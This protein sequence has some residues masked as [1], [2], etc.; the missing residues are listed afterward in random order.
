MNISERRRKILDIFYEK[1]PLSYRE[2]LDE[3][4]LS[5]ESALEILSDLD[6]LVFFRFLQKTKTSRKSELTPETQLEIRQETRGLM[7][8]PSRIFSRIK[9]LEREVPP[10]YRKSAILRVLTD[11]GTTSE[12]IVQKVKE[13]F[14]HVRW[15]PSLVRASLRILKKRREKK[16]NGKKKVFMYIREQD[17][18][19]Y[20]LTHDGNDL[21]TEDPIQ[22]YLYL[23]KLKDEFN[24]EFRAYEIL[25][26][27]AEYDKRGS[28]IS[29]G[30]IAS[31]LRTKYGIRG[32]KRRAIR[33]TLENMVL[34]GLIGV[35]GETKNREGHV[36]RLGP[37]VI[38]LYVKGDNGMKDY[39]PVKDFKE[40][41]EE[42]FHSCEIPTIKKDVKSRIQQILSD[43][44]Q[45]KED[46]SLRT[47][48]E[49][50]E[51]IMFLSGHL[52]QEG[53]KSW[54]K[55]VFPSIIAC[56]LSRLLPAEIS[57]RILTEYPPP[58]SPSKELYNYYNG[59]AREYYFNLTDAYVAGGEKEEA[60]RLFDR[61]EP[62]C[63]ESFDFL[64]L[65]GTL[66]L[67]KCS[68]RNESAVREV[69]QTFEMALKTSEGRERITALFYIGLTH[70]RRGDIKEAEKAWEQCLKLER[71]LDRQVKLSHNLANAYRAS[72]KLEEAKKLYERNI[73]LTE[74]F[75]GE[76]GEYRI[77]SL[78]GLANVFVDIGSWRKAEEI[79]RE[80]IK[81]ST[82]RGIVKIRA[83]AQTNR[84]VLLDRMG[85]YEE[86][87]SCHEEA[88]ILINKNASQEYGSILINKGDT[89]RKLKRLNEARDTFD[90]ARDL[91]FTESLG[92]I[93]AAELNR[94]DLYYDS[95]NIDESLELANLVFS[96]RWIG[97][98]RTEAEAQ[99]IR[100]KL[101]LKR[102]ELQKA[103]ESL[104]ESEKIFKELNLK[105]EMIE[106]YEL[107]ETY[108]EKLKNEEKV[109]S[110]RNEKEALKGLFNLS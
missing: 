7:I 73:A 36:Y 100:G 10:W 51:H 33:N 42:F 90:E 87:L 53:G 70:D 80:V 29:S 63:W 88:L 94:A 96:E 22:Q 55:R 39:H 110:C 65:K 50:V 34:S 89:L 38:P 13:Q 98:R 67:M 54:E 60:F 78:L 5:G 76:M 99:R 74:T 92:L 18:D 4:S 72:G 37:T 9:K 31:Y 61:L 43:L 23:R 2:I 30:K 64:I 58:T 17:Y 75:P 24:N 1:G 19:H 46:L 45:C 103:E 105:Y 81:E 85:M 91:I 93:Q 109:I 79:L 35:L 41:V 71:I 40:T 86:A 11:E 84:G 62:L 8:D 66:K 83:L 68:M 21:L 15:Q 20:I 101:F 57:I 47:P 49:W 97:N 27:V 77:K 16:E 25:R 44:E 26:L 82:Q 56:I 107:L 12:E 69:L 108:Y 104:K 102:N 14:P 95:G 28:G 106:V 3:A 52:K 59:I 48:E 6:T 32:N